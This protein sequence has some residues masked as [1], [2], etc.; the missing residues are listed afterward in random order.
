MIMHPGS[1]FRILLRG[2]H[3]WM[4]LAHV[5]CLQ[6]YWNKNKAFI[7]IWW[8]YWSPREE[9]FVRFKSSMK[10]LEKSSSGVQII[11][12]LI[13]TDVLGSLGWFT[14][15]CPDFGPNLVRKLCIWSKE[16][17]SH[18]MCEAAQAKMHANCANRAKFANVMDLGMQCVP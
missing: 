8:P 18:R 12:V 13:A 1:N 14:Q 16:A 9:K 15:G 7:L 5:P 11:A 17:P 3:A 2:R 10:R 6:W 4:W